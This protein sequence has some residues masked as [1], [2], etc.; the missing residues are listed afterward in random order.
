VAA[1]IVEGKTDLD[2]D[3]PM[4]NLAILEV[5]PRFDDLEP[6]HVPHC[7]GG[8]LDGILHRLVTADRGRTDEGD[9]FI[10]MVAHVS[11]L[12]RWPMAIRRRL[13]LSYPNSLY[14]VASEVAR[15]FWPLR[16]TQAAKDPQPAAH[17]VFR[18]GAVIKKN[19]TF[20][21]CVRGMS[22]KVPQGR[23]NGP[24]AVG[25]PPGAG[26]CHLLGRSGRRPPKKTAG[27]HYGDPAAIKAKLGLAQSRLAR[28]PPPEKGHTQNTQSEN[29][30]VG[31]RL[32]DGGERDVVNLN[33]GAA[34]GVNPESVC[35]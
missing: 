10:N 28:N 2:R 19:P 8:A 17:G 18:P 29:Q 25:A 3:L 32:G 20:Q 30:G 13:F 6:T 21:H 26:I 4:A 15:G 27:T 14:S 9:Y 23:L 12:F 11:C 16:K 5:S 24:S 35:G 33:P 34:N 22:V 31:T 7:F 1:L